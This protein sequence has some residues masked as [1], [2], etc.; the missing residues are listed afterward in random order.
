MPRKHTPPPH[1]GEQPEDNI[2]RLREHVKLFAEEHVKP[3]ENRV[4]MGQETIWEYNKYIHNL[5]AEEILVKILERKGLDVI[6]AALRKA[7]HGF[8]LGTLQTKFQKMP[9]IILSKREF[10]D[11][12]VNAEQDNHFLETRQKDQQSLI[13][14]IIKGREKLNAKKP[15]YLA[16][17]ELITSAMVLNHFAFAE[18]LGPEDSRKYM[19][20]SR[21]ISRYLQH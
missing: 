11:I 5:L 10:E 4:H 3:L 13:G 21:I 1:H 17:A 14:P 16:E 2:R 15:K 7:N 18:S 20:L 8:L 19:E 6:Q 9:R 12:I